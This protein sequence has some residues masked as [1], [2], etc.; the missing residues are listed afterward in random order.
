MASGL[1]RGGK[2]GRNGGGQGRLQ[3]KLVRAGQIKKFLIHG[4]EGY[5]NP[6]F[7]QSGGGKSDGTENQ[8]RNRNNHAAMW[9]GTNWAAGGDMLEGD[10][11]TLATNHALCHWRM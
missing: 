9:R 4:Q 1:W 7:L 11:A 8:N 6:E 5:A 10:S 2:R 3:A